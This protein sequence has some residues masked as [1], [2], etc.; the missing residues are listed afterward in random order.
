MDRKAVKQWFEREVAGDA[1]FKADLWK[2]TEGAFAHAKQ[3]KQPTRTVSLPLR[4]DG[5]LEQVRFTF[6]TM[7]RGANGH[8][9][10]KGFGIEVLPRETGLPLLATYRGHNPET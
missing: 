8:Y 1:K 6:N 2:R 3:H 7:A 4:P 9:V 5:N 10:R